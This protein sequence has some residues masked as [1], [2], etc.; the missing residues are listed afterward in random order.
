MSFPGWPHRGFFQAPFFGERRPG[1]FLLAM[2]GAES[3][4]LT[5]I[6][7][8]FRTGSEVPGFASSAKKK[9]KKAMVNP[10][11]RP[12]RYRIV[13]RRIRGRSKTDY[14]ARRFPNEHQKTPAPPSDWTHKRP[15]RPAQSYWWVI[16]CSAHLNPD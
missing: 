16:T 3:N 2:Q 15:T 13:K 10:E 12:P 7:P 8:T 5:D 1:L 11:S 6:T 4:S 9:K 14:A